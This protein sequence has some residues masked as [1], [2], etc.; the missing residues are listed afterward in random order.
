MIYSRNLA[1]ELLNVLCIV[2]GIF[3]LF[4]AMDLFGSLVKPIDSSQND[5]CNCKSMQDY[6]GK[7][8]Y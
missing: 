1:F 7:H 2:S 4:G 8:L 3:N 5:V 6:K